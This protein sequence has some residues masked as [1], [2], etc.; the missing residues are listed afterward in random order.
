MGKLQGLGHLPDVGD[1]GDQREVRVAEVEVA[2]GP[3][4]GNTFQI[5]DFYCQMAE[6]KSLNLSVRIGLV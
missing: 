2:H 3:L 1:N 4:G 5:R 6:G